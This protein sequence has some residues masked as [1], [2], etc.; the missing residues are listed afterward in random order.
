[1]R[2][3][4]RFMDARNT[5]EGKFLSV[6]LSVLLVFSFLNVTMFT[7]Y[8][9]AD[10]NE[11]SE[12]NSLTVEEPEFTEPAA[13]AEE[14]EAEKASEEVTTPA[15][16]EE[17]QETAVEE[18]PAATDVEVELQL[19][20]ATIAYDGANYGDGD[21]LVAPLGEDLK[22]SVKAAEGAEVVVA[23]TIGDEDVVLSPDADGNY[24]LKADQVTAALVVIG[25][26]AEIPEAGQAEEPVNEPGALKD[27]AQKAPA[28]DSAVYAAA[29]YTVEVGAAAT[30]EGS[31]NSN[32]YSYYYHEWTVSDSNIASINRNAGKENQG[33][34]SYKNCTVTGKSTGTVTVAHVWYEREWDR[35]NKAWKYTEAGSQD[36]TVKVTAPTPATGVSVSGSS[37]VAEFNTARLTATLSPAG[38]KAEIAWSS[39]DPSIATVD[40]NGRV[41]GVSA[42]TTTIRATITKADGSTVS[43]VHAITV[44]RSNSNESAIFYYLKTPTSDPNSND[45]GQ[46]GDSLGNGK[47]D[48]TGAVWVNDKNC[49]VSSQ[50]NRVVEWPTSVPGGV[51]PE[52]TGTWNDI[53]NAY[54][55]TVEGGN[56]TAEDIESITLVPYKISDNDDGYHVDCQ[57][58]VKAKGL[59]TARFYL[60]DAGATAYEYKGG[61]TVREGKTV[62]VPGSVSNLPKIKTADGRTY[63]LVAWRTDSNLIGADVAFPYTVTKNVDFYAKYVADYIVT[64]D[65]DGGS[66]NANPRTLYAAGDMVTVA[67]EQPQRAGYKF[68][69]WKKS[70]DESIVQPGDIFSM[71]EADVTLTA[72]WTPRTDLSYTVNYYLLKESSLGEPLLELEPAVDE[73]GD[74]I[75]VWPSYVERDVTCG[76]SVTARAV[77]VTGYKLANGVADTRELTI[78]RDGKVV[79]FY[80]VKDG[81]QTHSAT[82]TVRYFF[83]ETLADAKAKTTPDAVGTAEGK[84]LATAETWIGEAATATAVA[85]TTDK[86]VGYKYDSQDGTATATNAAGASGNAESVLN[87]YYVKDGGQ[88]HGL[89]ITVRYFLDNSPVKMDDE[90]DGKVYEET[91]WINDSITYKPKWEVIAANDKFP[92][93][94][95]DRINPQQDVTLGAGV[96]G[97]YGTT[98]TRTIDV[99]YKSRTDLTYTVRY[100][101]GSGND[102]APRKIVRDQTL[103]A[104]VNES[105]IKI[106]GY[107]MPEGEKTLTIQAENNVIEF[108]YAKRG[109]LSYM[110]NYLEQGTNRI[111]APAKVATAQTFDEVVTEQAID[112]AGYNKVAPTSAD[113]KITT[114]NNS[115]TFYYTARTDLSYTVRY[116]DANG[117]NIA[118]PKTVNG[119]IFGAS[120]TESP[121][122]VNGYV[123]PEG[124]K[125]ITIGL[126]GNE[127]VFEY[128]ATPQ[129]PVTPDN[130]GT[131]PTVPP[132]VPT[133]VTP[134]PT[135]VTPTPAPAP[136]PT[137]V[138]PAAPAA[139]PAAA[140]AA[141]T[142]APAAEPIEDDATPQAAAPAEGTPLAETEEIED[143]A[144]PMGAF[145]EPHCWV[146]WVMLLGILI[147]AAYG[148]IVVRRRLHLAD[149][150]D[151]YEK[152]VLGIED[153][154]P[155]AVPAD[156]RQA[157]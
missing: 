154:A 80:Y 20:D 120:V 150:V 116:V 105:A 123:M 5:A 109:D 86:F 149:D 118:T 111:L 138:T 21:K 131:T 7:D 9:G 101:D 125:T 37:T 43:A 78:D 98:V 141:A 11:A 103:G 137:V 27:P 99:Y 146:H 44:T 77:S 82:A 133:T 119:Q 49:Y 62:S 84:D 115:A 108:V 106:D 51:V 10:P 59:A 121:I 140:P 122:A 81:G 18:E 46:W 93:Y 26:V 52:G 39:D 94:E 8:A 13:T 74:P 35:K 112:I 23:A 79:D 127:I 40:G 53:F 96:V 69:G 124:T 134:V 30:L 2:T 95:L 68:A 56:V 89:I 126:T 55:V 135:P 17:K 100:V 139:T 144:T 72:Q 136:T 28:N 41:T 14:P 142:P 15:P 73:N 12:E 25:V 128:E 155:E 90:N 83:G 130:P 34:D 147:T 33:G 48:I 47:I 19:V 38:S 67:S 102:I 57:V 148:A 156:G 152:Q 91:S 1:M 3:I 114:G 36:F 29:N 6:L 76:A 16:V 4:A 157:L 113:I 45:T 110:V 66:W 129:P 71:P 97:D 54:K 85:N 50:P 58:V 32:Y 75:K 65:S 151:D 70:T 42:G 87:V 64:Y 31:G 145:D 88:T 132:I 24:I 61:E 104:N 63:R 143:E 60:W 92:G 117:N 107:V 22:F 153:E